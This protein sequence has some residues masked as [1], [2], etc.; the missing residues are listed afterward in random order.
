MLFYKALYIIA[1]VLRK[2][3]YPYVPMH[4][5]EWI[6][7]FSQCFPCGCLL[8]QGL[9]RVEGDTTSLHTDAS[10]L[11][12]QCQDKTE[13]WE[14]VEEKVLAVYSCLPFSSHPQPSRHYLLTFQMSYPLA[15]T[16]AVHC[17]VCVLGEGREVALV[18]KHPVD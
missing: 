1:Y 10:F 5:A 17:S 11:G 13:C 3:D 2:K 8:E 14:S 16:F 6:Q 18:L 15:I 4:F 7:R 12:G 9:V